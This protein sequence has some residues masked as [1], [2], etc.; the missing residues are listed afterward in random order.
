MAN[1]LGFYNPQFYANEALIWLRKRL[2]MLG[3]VYRGYDEERR[4]FGQGDT[5]NIRRP[6]K[7]EVR[8]APS[9]SQDINPDSLK[10]NLDFHKEVK[11][12]LT[13]K[14]LAFTGERIINEHI[15]PAA[16]AIGDFVDTVLAQLYQDIPWHVGFSKGSP[17]SSFVSVMTDARQRLFDNEVP[18]SDRRM[19][20]GLVDGYLENKFLQEQA[21]SQ[22]QGAGDRG[23]ASQETGM[24]GP[25]FG[26]NWFASQNAQQHTAGSI[27]ASAP[28]LDGGG[29]AVAQGTSEI[30]IDDTTLTG[31]VKKGDTLV[32]D[33][34]TQR[35]AITADATA[36]GNAV[37]VQITPPLVQ[38]YADEAAVTFDQVDHTANLVFHRN[39]FAVAFGALPAELIR[40]IAG[41]QVFVAQ[42][43]ESGLSVR[44]RLYYDGDNSTVKVA[45]DV[46]FG[47]KTLDPNLATRIRAAA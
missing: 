13:D 43:Q 41:A 3:S 31:T 29:S 30:T 7:F 24:L 17:P 42:D 33:G 18:L 5:I 37:T 12:A 26:I 14:E 21:F 16:Y 40:R 23:V 11:I 25:K 15:Q 35:Y 10:L 47:V 19:V 45:L 27:T 2:G 38:E 44:S 20:H 4:T 9:T 32:I 8:D 6:S 36:A 22:A 28:K 39:A 46:L 1:N 34:G